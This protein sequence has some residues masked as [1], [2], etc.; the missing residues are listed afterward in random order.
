MNNL[1]DKHTTYPATITPDIE[2]R[3]MRAIDKTGREPRWFNIDAA[4]NWLARHDDA[5]ADTAIKLYDYTVLRTIV[6]EWENG[7]IEATTGC[8]REWNG[9]IWRIVFDEWS[10]G[11]NG[12]LVFKVDAPGSCERPRRKSKKGRYLSDCYYE[13]G[14]EEPT[15]AQLGL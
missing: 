14:D 3:V 1:T 4:C 2:N 10:F 13:D 6:E 11:D 8:W 15:L 12:S 5:S 7:A 9:H